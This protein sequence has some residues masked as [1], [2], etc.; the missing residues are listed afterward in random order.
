[1]QERGFAVQHRCPGAALFRRNEN[2]V[3]EALLRKGQNNVSLMFGGELRWQK[4]LVY[5]G[6]KPG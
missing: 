4:E 1:M 3:G 2:F 5:H 6:P